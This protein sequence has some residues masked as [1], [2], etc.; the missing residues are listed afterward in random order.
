MKETV[1]AYQDAV[2]AFLEKRFSTEGPAPR[3]TEAMRYSLMAGGKRIRPAMAMAACQASGG[4]VEDVLPAAAALEMVHTYSLI[5]DD[6]PAMD[7]DD[8]RRGQPTSHIVYGDALAILAGDGLLTEAFRCL[9]DPNWKIPA[10]R[11]IEVVQAV[12]YGAGAEGMVA[13]QVLDLENEGV[14][15]SEGVL[16]KIHVHKTERLISSA[17]VAGGI[18]G[19][20]EENQLKA[21][22]RYGK[23]IG[24]AFQIADDILDLTATT[25]ELGKSV[26]S[27]L[28]KEKVTYPALLG[29]DESR[30][31]AEVLLDEALM[32]LESF[33]DSAETLRFLA[34]YI[35][36]RRV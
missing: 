14:E 10:D 30:R 17:V 26:K 19:G 7:D 9:S 16:E 35:V 15:C 6:L 34:K 8:L 1:H 25:E 23:N 24:L 18:A 21:L 20:A 32:A 31:R 28:K 36:H 29:L 27:D 2:N 3:L 33:G 12:A 13:G 5:H 4:T 22:A 11:R